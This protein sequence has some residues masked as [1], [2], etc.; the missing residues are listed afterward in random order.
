MLR[1]PGAETVKSVN[2]QIADLMLS[3]A[4]DA[5]Q[6]FGAE[7]SPLYDGVKWSLAART[8]LDQALGDTVHDLRD[9]AQA[10]DE[11]PSTGAPGELREAVREDL[12]TVGERLGQDN[13]FQH[14]ADL[15][16]TLTTLSARVAETVR[17]M[18][19]GQAQRLREA[20]Q[21]LELLP[22][23]PTFTAEEQN[24][25]LAEL[26]GM[27]I[28]VGEGAAG[29]KRLV[30]QQYDVERTIADLKARIA[31]DARVRRLREREAETRGSFRG[32]VA[33]T[34]QPLA[35]PARIA[36]AAELDALIRRLQALR[37]DV[38][39]TEFDLVIS[40]E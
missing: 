20:E 13:F 34:R 23:W 2:Q 6:R 5:P 11:M 28:T 12:K 33:K 29:L 8:A 14:Q 37:I 18:A 9:L 17:V 38:A 25:A 30:A 31:Q 22:E 1:L 10:V 32:M 19:A 15:A 39:Y 4:S 36:T 3:D 26:Q 27:T 7:Q 16:S 24:N 35:V 21:D 40:E